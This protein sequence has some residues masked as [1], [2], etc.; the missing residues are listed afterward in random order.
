M[1]SGYTQGELDNVIA[2]V[3]GAGLKVH[4]SRGEQ[5]AIVGVIGVPITDQVQEALEV[6]PGVELVARYADVLQ[7]GARNTQNYLLL[8]AVGAAGKPVLLKRG[9]AVTIEEWLLAAEYVMAGGNAQVV[10]CE[11]GIRTFETA[12]RNTLDL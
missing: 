4:L 9:M 7:I 10:L 12:T 11:R 1:H 8:E 3:E 5:H 6:L 2:H